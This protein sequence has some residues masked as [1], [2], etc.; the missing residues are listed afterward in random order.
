MP[1][2]VPVH[3]PEA[4]RQADD[5]CRNRSIAKPHEDEHRPHMERPM[6]R[7]LANLGSVIF[8]TFDLGGCPQAGHGSIRQAS[9]L[10]IYGRGDVLIFLQKARYSGAAV[11]E[12]CYLR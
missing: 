5:V 11:I 10:S 4:E 6:R 3:A 7:T 9:A 8:R 12:S 1:T 2:A